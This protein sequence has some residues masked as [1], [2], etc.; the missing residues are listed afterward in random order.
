MV[1]TIFNASE[2]MLESNGHFLWARILA[3]QR[4]VEI[5]RLQE[6]VNTYKK[7]NDDLKVKVKT[8]K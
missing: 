8:L 4:A 5:I 3:E 7:E 2:R 6:V 1:D